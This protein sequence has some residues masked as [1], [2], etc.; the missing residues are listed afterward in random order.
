MVPIPRKPGVLL[1]AA[2]FFSVSFFSG[3]EAFLVEPQQYSLDMPMGWVPVEI[4][5][6]RATFAGPEDCAYLQVKAFPGDAFS[7]P[8]RISSWASEKLKAAGDELPFV[9]SGYPAVFRDLI[10]SSGGFSFQ[11]Y[12]VCI[13]GDDWDYFISSFTTEDL[14]NQLHPFMVSSLDS[15]AL[16][17]EDRLLPGPVS[18]FY[19][20]S[21]GEE[22]LE[23]GYIDFE[24]RIIPFSYDR[25][26]LEASRVVI[27]REA[28]VLS[29]YTQSRSEEAWERYY[30]IL[31]RDNHARLQGLHVALEGLPGLAGTG[32]R[33][34]AETLLRW[35]QSFEF[36]RP[37]HLSDLYSPLETAVLR[38][39]DC[40]SRGLL[41]T[42]LLEKR[43]IDAVLMVSTR[44]A[45]SMVAVDV[46]GPGARFPYGNKAYLVAETSD[47][48][49][50]GMI[51]ADMADPEGWIGLDLGSDAFLYE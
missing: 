8:A 4:L 38:S 51:A 10:F 30:R 17:G 3:A 11:G 26:A 20:G 1:S 37:G 43:G 32:K 12:G 6:D 44:Y 33:D 49:D 47:Q 34:A 31:Y 15:F 19:A 25:Y 42:I 13:D 45:H 39:G 28:Q 48:V 22:S 36:Q 27:E 5:E 23:S 14:Y 24:G 21:Y 50:L 16:G 29:A 18:Q 46:E 7:D 2:L 35:V 9:Y 41:Y 40:D